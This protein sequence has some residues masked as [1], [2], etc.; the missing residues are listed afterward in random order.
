MGGEVEISR[1]VTE[2]GGV[3]KA[4]TNGVYLCTLHFGLVWPS[5]ESKV[6]DGYVWPVGFNWGE[7]KRLAVTR[8]D[9]LVS[10]IVINEN[11]V[12]NSNEGSSCGWDTGQVVWVVVIENFMVV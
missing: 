5:V 12:L 2:R 11:G 4:F 1:Y 8:K 3:I 7:V 9:N 6:G 10:D